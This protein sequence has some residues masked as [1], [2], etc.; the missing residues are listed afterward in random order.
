[1]TEQFKTMAEYRHWMARHDFTDGEYPERD[2]HSLLKIVED[3]LPVGERLHW[4]LVCGR[5]AARD[6]PEW[7]IKEVGELNDY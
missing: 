4:Q 3:V 7:F 1:M 6:F 2:M 5:Y